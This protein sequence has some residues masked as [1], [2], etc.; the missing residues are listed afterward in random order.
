MLYSSGQVRQLEIILYLKYHY[1]TY[2]SICSHIN[3]SANGV[4]FNNWS[5]ADEIKIR[6]ILSKFPVL[7]LTLPQ[8]PIP[9]PALV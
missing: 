2:E 4:P 1:N 5:I 3:I 9:P 8:C 7:A 6:N